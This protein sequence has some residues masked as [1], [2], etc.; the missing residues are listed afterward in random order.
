MTTDIEEPPL[1]SATVTFT[2]SAKTV[3][4]DASS[5]LTILE[6]AE[7]A[8]L[9]PDYGCRSAMCGTCEVRILK[10]QVYGPEGD[11]PQGIF[12]CQSKPAT[13]EIEI[14]L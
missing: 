8:G 5:N 12:I 6:L 4:W 1:S 7:Q 3:R 10:G 13:A 2:K 9:K 11:R 14:E